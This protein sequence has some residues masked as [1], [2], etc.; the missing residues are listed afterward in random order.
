MT[1]LSSTSPCQK[2]TIKTKSAP[3]STS[4]THNGTLFGHSLSGYYA[5]YNL[6]CFPD[7]P[8]HNFIAASV[9]FWWADHAIFGMEEELN[10]RIQV[11]PARLL[12]TA[13]EKEGAEQ[14]AESEKMV[15]RLQRLRHIGL[16]ARFRVYKG[17]RHRASAIASLVDGAR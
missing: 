10:R 12:L 14:I 11:A 8:F 3:S 9:S 16:E 13:G 1:N 7:T 5:L 15:R 4:S 17:A 6:L 2:G